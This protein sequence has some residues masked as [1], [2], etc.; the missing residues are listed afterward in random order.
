MTSPIRTK[1]GK[2]DQYDKDYFLDYGFYMK[3]RSI[4]IKIAVKQIL[5]QTTFIH[6]YNENDGC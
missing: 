4:H 3:R 5:A 1:V 6:R 2:C